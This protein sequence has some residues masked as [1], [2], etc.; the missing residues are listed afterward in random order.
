MYNPNTL[1]DKNGTIYR[2]LENDE[3]N[4][5]LVIDCI[6]QCN[7]MFILKELFEGAKQIT[8]EEL[9]SAIE[10]VRNKLNEITWTGWISKSAVEYATEV[11][12]NGDVA[13]R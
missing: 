7:P 11:L 1:W 4:S 9:Q 6:R 12:P 13:R 10:E 5:L 8:E 3:N 2:V